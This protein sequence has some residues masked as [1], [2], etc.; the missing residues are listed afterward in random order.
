MVF[1]AQLVE[2]GVACTP[3]F[4]VSTPE[5]RQ[6]SIDP[7]LPCVIKLMTVFCV[8][9]VLE[10]QQQQLDLPK[11]RSPAAPDKG[12]RYGPSGKAAWT[13]NHDTNLTRLGHSRPPNSQAGLRDGSSL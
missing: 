12:K 5:R 7:C 3:L 9:S 13:V 8:H 4:T 2:G 1:S 6:G 11:T 10:H